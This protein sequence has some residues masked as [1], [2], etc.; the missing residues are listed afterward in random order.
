MVSKIGPAVLLVLCVV[1]VYFVLHLEIDNRQDR[2]LDHSGPEALEH[3]RFQEAFG[4]DD[5]VVIAISGKPLFDEEALDVMVEVMDRLEDNDYVSDVSGIPALYRENFGEEDPEALEEEMTS[6]PFYQ[7]LFISANHDVAGLLVQSPVLDSPGA[8]REL[9]DHIF[10]SIQPLRD[11]GFRVD[12]VGGAV[13]DSAINS[14]TQAESLRMFP[15][16]AVASLL[17]LIALLRSL[18]ATAVVL[19]CGCV[20]ELLTLGALVALGYTLTIVTSV[21]P[22]IIWVLTLANCVHL[23]NHYQRHLAA[24]SSIEKAI[25]ETLSALWFSCSLS[26]V[27]TAFGFLSLVVADIG[28]IREL[29][30][31]M[32]LG[33]VISLGVNLVLCPFLLRAMNVPAPERFGQRTGEVLANL[34]DRITRHPRP[35]VALFAAL[36]LWGAYSVTQVRTEA[37]ATKFLPRDGDLVKSYEFVAEN[38]TGMHTLEIVIDTPGGWLNP[39]Y[40]PAIDELAAGLESSEFVPRVY[41]PLEFLRKTNQWDH[42]FDTE[43]YVLPET[44]EEAEELITLLSEEDDNQLPHFVT[45]DGERVR[46][47]VL[48]NTMEAQEFGAIVDRGREYIARLEAPLTGTITGMATRMQAM[49]LSLIMTQVKSFSLA[50]VLVFVSILVGLRSVKLTLLSMIPNLMPFLSIF[51]TMSLLNIPLNAGTVM[52]ASISLGI[53][54][55]DTVH[56][57]VGFHRHRARGQSKSEAIH[58]TLSKVGPSLVVTTLTACIGFFALSQSAFPPISCFGLLSGIAIIVALLAD[59]LLVPAIFALRSESA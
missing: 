10:T 30:A 22:L 50:F 48:I 38:L 19:I 11:Y 24:T 36:I 25:Q 5:F 40:W 8:F 46:V 33:M 53:A 2:L 12:T 18:K 41:T 58:S 34:G 6:T 16:A 44:R 1:S 7:G 51:A 42:D 37:D 13:F 20:T 54:V 43:Y 23:V 52:V 59:I 4:N 56:F 26:A 3:A 27:T 15:I 29:G 9:S 17:V 35:V 57:F 55:D 32:A 14:I 45:E 31:F 39:E 21:L 47:S 49:Q 28:L